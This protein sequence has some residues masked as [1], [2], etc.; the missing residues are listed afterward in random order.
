MLSSEE[1][2]YLWERNERVS[3]AGIRV[4]VFLFQEL[5]AAGGTAR[6]CRQ[7][8]HSSQLRGQF[9]WC[10]VYIYIYTH[11]RSLL[12]FVQLIFLSFS[13]FLVLRV[14]TC[15]REQRY[16]EFFFSPFCVC[17]QNILRR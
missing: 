17:K 15:S 5:I 11:Y 8:L 1:G 7:R 9:C 2:D 16:Q 14:L 4:C 10:V 6:L 3:D 12:F 13:F